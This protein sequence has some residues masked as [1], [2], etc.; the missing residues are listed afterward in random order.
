M[1][2][3]LGYDFDAAIE[4]IIEDGC[5]FCGGEVE[6]EE[7]LLPG[8]VAVVVCRKRGLGRLKGDPRCEYTQKHEL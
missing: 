4:Q 6:V 2:A 3:R 5:E 8:P 7:D 1:S